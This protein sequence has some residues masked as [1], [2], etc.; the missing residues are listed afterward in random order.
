MAKTRPKILFL[1]GSGTNAEIF[2]IRTS[3][4]LPQPA[5]QPHS[6]APSLPLPQ[7]AQSPQLN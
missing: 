7:T 3:S 1:H 2:Q 6:L 4:P 5:L